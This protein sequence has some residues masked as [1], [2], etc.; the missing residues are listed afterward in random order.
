[1]DLRRSVALNRPQTRE[2][3]RQ[4]RAE[5]EW[6]NWPCVKAT[7]PNLPLGTTTYDIHK[8]LQRFGKLEYIRIEETR[9]GNF[10]RY[11][12]VMFK[13]PPPG[14]APWDP[15]YRYGIDFP[16]GDKDGKKA[17]KVRVLLSNSQPT[18]Q[19]IESR[20]CSGL[21][22]PS[23]M[24]LLGNSIDFGYLENPTLMVVKASKSDA[25]GSSIRLVLNL[26]RLE[27]E[28]H[29][30]V[31]I[32]SKGKTAERAYRFF[33]ALDD[34]FSL[35]VIQSSVVI[36]AKHPPCYS[37]QLK[38]AMQLSHDPKSFKWS[39]DDTLSR[40]TDI[41]DEKETYHKIDSSPVSVQKLYNS[42]DLAHWTTFRVTLKPS[43]DRP[44]SSLS[45]FLKALADF[46][47]RIAQGP[48]FK[49]VRGSSDGAPFWRMLGDT[50]SL[51]SLSD[52]L[53]CPY[54]DFDLRYQLEVCISK[55]W[56]NEYS[57]D[58]NFLQ[59]LTGMR[60]ERAK[61]M[62][63]HVDSYQRRVY[64]PMSIFTDL[65]Y[66]KPVRARALPSN[67]AE[68]YHATVT[69]TRI[70][71]HTPSVEITNRIVRKYR[72]FS[73]RFLR[74]R[75]E[76]EPHRG[77]T[78][79]YPATNG[80]MKLI[81]ERVRRTLKN[82]IVLGDRH[83]EFLAWGNSQLREHGAY[84]FASS[85]NPVI[86]ADS[87][88]RDMGTFDHE[89]VVAKRAA[90]M[91]QCFSTTKPVPVLSRNSWKRDPIPDIING[92]YT[93]TDGVGKISL[94]AAQ[95]V[96]SNLNLGG[97]HLPSA[98]QFRLGGCKGVL[99]VD[100]KLNGVDIKIRPSQYKFSCDSD[101]LE[102]IRV[103]EFWQPFL[104]RQL[105]LV[106]SALGVPDKVFLHKQSDC[107]KALDAALV[108]DAAALRALRATV[109]PNSTTLSIAAL[110]EAG[111]SHIHEPFV[112]SLLRLWRAWTLKYL[113]EK[114]KIPITQGAFVLGVVDET[115]TLKGHISKTG[116]GLD[117][118]R[119][120]MEKSLPEVFIQYTDPE[121]KG[122]RRIVEGI[123]VIARNPSL[124]RGDVRVVKAV[125]VP[126]LHHHCD[127][128]V[129]PATGDRDL[130]SMCSG[131]DLDGD[132][133][134]VTWDPDLI[135]S[136]WN[137][138]PFHYNAPKPI[139]KEE[140]SVGDIINFFYDYMQND[141]LGRI[142]NAHLAAADYLHDGL[143][144]E[145]CLKLVELHSM[146]VDYP[147]T[148]VPAEMSRDLERNNWPHFM[149]KK[150]AGQYHSKK[151]LGQLYDAVER[152]KFKPHWSGTFD[153][154]IL[155]HAPADEIIETVS[156][157]KKSYDESMRRIMAQ[158]QISSEFEVWST[159]VLHHSKVSRDFKFHEEIGQHAKTLKEQYYEA[160]CQ[161]AGGC[162]IEK[163]KPFAIAA[164]H[165]THDE[166]RE[167]LAQQQN[168][169][170][171]ASEVVESNGSGSAVINMPF[172]SFPWVLQDVLVKIARNTIL[173]DEVEKVQ[174]AEQQSVAGDE[175]VQVK[176][177]DLIEEF[178]RKWTY[179][180]DH[181]PDPY[182]PV[183]GSADIAQ[184]EIN[185]AA[186]TKLS[187]ATG[188]QPPPP[189][190]DTSGE[191][192]PIIAQA[193]DLC[194]NK[195]DQAA[196]DISSMVSSNVPSV[197]LSNMSASTSSDD[198]E[199]PPSSVDVSSENPVSFSQI[200]GSQ[201]LRTPLRST[202]N[203][204]PPLTV[205]EKLPLKDPVLM[206]EEEFY[207]FEADSGEDDY[208][209]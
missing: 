208:T 37:R 52:Q 14:R 79:L 8:N 82:G 39:A 33:V 149:E 204:A 105:I 51:Q 143:N 38:E 58:K 31:T 203:N 54:L 104:N 180:G 68:I 209:F 89:K 23:E 162:D 44:D 110:I 160:F 165:V 83:Y 28:V 161:E 120:E 50:S 81:F 177:Q 145:Q 194:G 191:L 153:R 122:V 57:L 173:H 117:A 2:V 154:R 64:D 87:I 169:R 86:T 187:T 67:C 150:R 158:H 85:Q 124:H 100:P 175:V 30:P 32:K 40:Q 13:P 178:G 76:D 53:S 207:D 61:Q 72:R 99:A 113:K 118:S 199:P 166:L 41:V 136:E 179:H 188:M 69:A 93:F 92:P 47:I 155:I 192:P 26:R 18:A 172:I 198:I 59:H 90:R 176:G 97:E 71:F 101:E 138:E 7:L 168:D 205:H 74:V 134:I 75:F 35:S 42:I 129:M 197:V 3:M 17:H 73:D 103:A 107:I 131:G 193:I 24:I 185:V 189:K 6:R 152:T 96:K 164:Y 156:N 4:S 46:N 119:Q 163:L 139:Q 78:R 202:L 45:L 147:K 12:N 183:A 190:H 123:C 60:P 128:V 142:A 49:V 201:G 184:S 34:Q 151:I 20:A 108:N 111:F 36:H 121:Q 91:G 116:P 5:P 10:A 66:S 80:K 94:L 114:A 16:L 206:T 195:E 106:L 125:N 1:M 95:L 29:F 56:L 21:R 132:D 48:S 170:E 133:Y 196:S 25:R 137:A 186:Q 63:V 115:K 157:L 55:G 15:V 43:T 62:L 19:F 70:L 27:L 182:V 84:F 102:I 159:F 22:Y 126:E 77:Q 167:A 181:L 109:D 65:R 135:P 200:S 140:I 144:S 88:R 146:A 174:I 171:E 127:V 112:T 130:P 141:F 98:F 148:G 9:Q 11:A